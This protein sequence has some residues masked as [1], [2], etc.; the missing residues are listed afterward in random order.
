MVQR[1]TPGFSRSDSYVQIILDLSLPNKVIKFAGTEISI[2][3]YVFN[4]RFTRYNAI[5]FNLTPSI[6]LSF[7]Q[8]GEGN[9]REDFYLTKTLLLTPEKYLCFRKPNSWIPRIRLSWTFL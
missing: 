9:E 4:V 7:E 5:Y 6:P 3:W 8:E 2:K 1:L